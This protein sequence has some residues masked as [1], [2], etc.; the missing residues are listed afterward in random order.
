M[1]SATFMPVVKAFVPKPSL[2]CA[3][4]P[5]VI[6]LAVNPLRLATVVIEPKDN[7]PDP[8]VYSTSYMPPPVIFTLALLPR[9]ILPVLLDTAS[10]RM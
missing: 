7:P 6:L 8:S 10:L 3:L 1:A 5:T 4:V 9:L 2:E